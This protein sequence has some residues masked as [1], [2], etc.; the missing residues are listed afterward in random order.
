[1]ITEQLEALVL[2]DSVGALDP[3]SRVELQVRLDALTPEQRSE[4]ARLYDAAAA[5]ALSAPNPLSAGLAEAGVW[6]PGHT[7]LVRLGLA[8]GVGLP[9]HGS[10]RR[11]A[12]GRGAR[13][14]PAQRAGVPPPPQGPIPRLGSGDESGVL[15]SILRSPAPIVA[16]AQMRLPV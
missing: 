7:I 1:M 11:C 9:P 13:P 8:M 14:R 3:D 16:L 10:T 6:P 5:L 2:A 4:V 15:R 12:L